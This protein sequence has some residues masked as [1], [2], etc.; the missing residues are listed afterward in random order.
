MQPHVVASSLPMGFESERGYMRRILHLVLLFAFQA[1]RRPGWRNIRMPVLEG[2]NLLVCLQL[3]IRNSS[4]S[5]LPVS[6]AVHNMLKGGLL[7]KGAGLALLAATGTAHALA[8]LPRD[9]A[10]CVGTVSP[11]K[12]SLADIGFSATSSGVLASNMCICPAM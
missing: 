1:C 6:P 8:S 4:N 2:T 11:P 7:S 12:H 10:S 3:S 9:I 5:S